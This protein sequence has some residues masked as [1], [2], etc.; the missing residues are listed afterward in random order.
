MHLFFVLFS[1]NLTKLPQYLVWK[2][3]KVHEG[4]LCEQR[5]EPYAKY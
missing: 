5:L 1:F 3:F 2:N 4:M